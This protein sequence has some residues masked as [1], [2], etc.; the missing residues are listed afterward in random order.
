MLGFASAVGLV[1]G[2]GLPD[3]NLFGWSWRSVFLI[4]VPVAA[5]AL[6]AGARI[7][8][9]TRDPGAHRPNLPG[10]VL[11]AG[12]L[13]AVVYPLLE[14]RQLGWPAWVWALLVA[15]LAGACALGVREYRRPSQ[16]VA[17]LLRPAPFRIP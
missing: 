14:G 1:L 12:S 3:V 6:I 10:A 16:P 7:I 9:E 8:P 11:L 5:C 17:P 13:V 15:G 4:N 2:G